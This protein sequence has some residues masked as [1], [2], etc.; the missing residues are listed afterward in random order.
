M[1]WAR[2]RRRAR[3]A[4]VAAKSKGK[5]DVGG[6]GKGEET[7][8]DICLLGCGRGR[9]AEAGKGRGKGGGNAFVCLRRLCCRSVR[10]AA[11]VYV[12]VVWGDCEERVK[13][14]KRREMEGGGGCESKCQSKRTRG[15]PKKSRTRAIQKHAKILPDLHCL[16]IERSSE[17]G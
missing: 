13:A 2:L 3:P 11:C 16:N 15:K 5:Q 1:V 6:G 7:G 12:G 4:K 14:G 9:G 8:F 17:C 10:C